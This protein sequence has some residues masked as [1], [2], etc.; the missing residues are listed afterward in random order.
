MANKHLIGVVR[1]SKPMET[2]ELLLYLKQMHQGTYYHVAGIIDFGKKLM[3]VQLRQHIDTYD[4]LPPTKSGFRTGFSCGTILFDTT[5]DFISELDDRRF[6]VLVLLDFTKAFDIINHELFLATA[7]Y[8]GLKGTQHIRW[9][10]P[11]LHIRPFYIY[12]V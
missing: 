3:K 5:D 4:L 2:E 11:G 7:R 9:Y 10:F 8:I 1:I 12:L 6:G